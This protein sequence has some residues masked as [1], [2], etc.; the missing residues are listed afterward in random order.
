MTR[1]EISALFTERWTRGPGQDRLWDPLTLG[2]CLAG[3]RNGLHLWDHPWVTRV[4]L[5]RLLPRIS[6]L[7]PVTLPCNIYLIA[8]R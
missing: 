5:A 3:S 8:M 6:G 4:T 1:N 2:K 7:V